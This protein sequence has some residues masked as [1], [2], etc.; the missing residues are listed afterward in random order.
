MTCLACLN[1]IHFECLYPVEIVDVESSHFSET[2]A[3]VNCCCWI[4]KPDSDE[5]AVRLV[6]GFKDPT[7]MKDP[8]STGR[9]RA[10]QLKPII[11]DMVCEWSG[12][13]FAG[14]GPIPIVGCTGTTLTKVKGNQQRTGNIHHG[15]D[16]DVLN[17]TDPNL[18]RICG[19]CHARW[20]TL[21]D[22]L[23]GARP[24]PG[25]PFVPMDSGDLVPHDK[26]TLASSEQVAFSEKWWRTDPKQRKTLTFR[27]EDNVG[28]TDLR[29]VRVGQGS[30]E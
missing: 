17:N 28:D 6:G 23:Y 24:T 13:L 11:E 30:S 16:K 26:Y 2:G 10:A 9:K 15:P 14:G 18:H 1:G 5:P 27:L 21:N 4:E 8:M 7:D 3:L 12:L 20:H 29:S 25:T 22:P 19:D